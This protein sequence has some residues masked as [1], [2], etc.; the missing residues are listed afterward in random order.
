MRLTLFD[1]RR[2]LERR[3]AMS[4]EAQIARGRSIAAAEKAK[5]PK[6]GDVVAVQVRSS[7]T[8][9]HGPTT[10]E[11]TWYLG[12]AG[13]VTRAGRVETAIIVRQCGD[14]S[15]MREERKAY[16]RG[17]WWTPY[18]I[19]RDMQPAAKAALNRQPGHEYVNRDYIRQAIVGAAA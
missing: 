12:V 5:L 3:T 7:V 16:D 10:S 2:V 8:A 1:K 9:M 15:L 14:G 4:I 6:R 11:W 19:Q 17:T 13:H 18:T